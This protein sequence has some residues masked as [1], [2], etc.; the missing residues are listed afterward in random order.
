MPGGYRPFPGSPLHQT[1]LGVV[2]LGDAGATRPRAV[3]SLEGKGVVPAGV[4]GVGVGTLTAR[5]VRQNV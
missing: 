2:F 4:G 3:R 5:E 1:V